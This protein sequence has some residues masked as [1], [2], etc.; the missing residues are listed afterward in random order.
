[1]NLSKVWIFI[2]GILAGAV[3][4]GDDGGQAVRDVFSGLRQGASSAFDAGGQGLSEFGGSV[5]E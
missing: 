4:L 3:F 5:G 1:M 2:L